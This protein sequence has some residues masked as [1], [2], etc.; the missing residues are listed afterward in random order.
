MI[1]I[2]LAT[3]NGEKYLRAQIDSIFAQTY[4]DW[5][6]VI[7]D[8]CSSDGT[9]AIIQEYAT[10]YADK[11]VVIDN[12]NIN[13]G[14]TLSFAKLIEFSSAKYMMLCD[15]DDVWLED[16]VEL[17]IATIQEK[18]KD[19]TSNTPVLLFTDLKVVDENLNVLHDSF[20]R[21]QKYILNVIS[22]YRK[23][24]A[25]NVVTG[26]T[27]IFNQASKR[28][29]LPM[30][31]DFVHDMWIAINVAYYGKLYSIDKPTILYRQHS[32]N[33]VGAHK[34]GFSYFKSKLNFEKLKIYFKLKNSLPFKI[35]LCSFFAY[36][37]YFSACRILK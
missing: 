17:S 1:D 26:C 5:R 14:A 11:I 10:Q 22:D 31:A 3:Y 8:D 36:K 32:S 35:S 15:Q 23:L 30:P 13:I 16:K 20:W 19:H 4:T 7:R 29:V 25:L 28:V 2:L 21:H 18:E 12:G 24:L 33:T 37:L 27:T 6:L 9:P 34:I